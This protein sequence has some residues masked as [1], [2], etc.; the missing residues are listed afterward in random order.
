MTLDIALSVAK[1]SLW[2]IRPRLSRIVESG[3]A[4]FYRLFLDDLR[5]N[6]RETCEHFEAHQ[7]ADAHEEI[8][9]CHFDAL[10]ALT[11]ALSKP[12]IDRPSL[13][14]ALDTLNDLAELLEPAKVH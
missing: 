4:D 8:Y 12:K 9:L 11:Y 10:S 3:D 5:N 6:L 13:R 2:Q 1:F 14:A 7:G